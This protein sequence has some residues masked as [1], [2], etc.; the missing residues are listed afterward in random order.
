MVIESF[1]INNKFFFFF[2]IFFISVVNFFPFNNLIASDLLKKQKISYKITDSENNELI[3]I[4]DGLEYK[5][6]LPAN[7]MCINIIE[8]LDFDGDAL[9][10]ALIEHNACGGNGAANSYF[11]VSYGGDGVFHVTKEFGYS[12]EEPLIEKWNNKISVIVEKTNFGYNNDDA[13]VETERYILK[14]G[15]ALLTESITKTE[16]EALKEIRAK[17]FSFENPDEIKF[18]YFDLDGDNAED[19]ITCTFWE[20][21]GTIL[22]S[23]I[24]FSSGITSE[25]ISV[26]CKRVGILDTKTNNVN[27]LVCGIDNI[28]RWNGKEYK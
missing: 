10:D 17:E 9:T 6:G 13:I 14:N 22:I 15:E 25:N 26:G 8:Q 24:E 1:H 12:W 3:A 28:L 18:L 23:K 11:F 20:R 21:W 7:I 19:K 16:L 4:V 2:T 5:I 27:D